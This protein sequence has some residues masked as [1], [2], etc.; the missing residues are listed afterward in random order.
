MAVSPLCSYITSGRLAEWLSSGRRASPVPRLCLPSPQETTELPSGPHTNTINW[1]LSWLISPFDLIGIGLG[2]SKC[3]GD[4]LLR[5]HTPTLRWLVPLGEAEETFH[6]CGVRPALPDLSQY[7][8]VGCELWYCNSHGRVFLHTSQTHHYLT[9]AGSKAHC[10][11]TCLACLR[12]ALG[13][14]PNTGGKW[15][16]NIPTNHILLDVKISVISKC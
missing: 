10:Q 3:W 1:P 5:G 9:R 15:N 4:K 7:I 2:L 8:W 16:K 12:K 14:M 13:S 6:K 11:S